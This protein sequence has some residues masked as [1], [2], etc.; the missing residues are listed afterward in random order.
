MG[1]IPRV[2]LGVVIGGCVGEVVMVCFQPASGV[3]SVTGGPLLW[4]GERKLG[5]SGVPMVT[6]GAQ[7]SLEP[8]PGP[9]GQGKMT[10]GEDLWWLPDDWLASL[11]A[12]M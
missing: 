3:G 9:G 2:R 5:P 1:C 10:A 4:V 6:I 7:A 12:V 8:G 11:L